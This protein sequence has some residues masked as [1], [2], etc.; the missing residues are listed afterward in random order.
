MTITALV[1]IGLLALW[2]L[3]LAARLHFGGMLETW[4][5]AELRGARL[6]MVE[7]DLFAGCGELALA[8]RPDRVY[9]T[10]TNLHVPVEYKTRN[11]FRLYESDRAQLSLQ[12]WQLR[13]TGRTTG[14]TGYVVVSELGSRKRRALAVQLGN[15][16]Y[17]EALMR[18]YHALRRNGDDAHRD[19]G[20]KC[21][22][23]G[24]RSSC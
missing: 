1:L 18:R 24:H 3:W 2:V 4:R 6:V 14:P 8:G 15:D 10:R 12:A 16:A 20:P 11:G 5:P 21:K 23:C 9:R 7:R 13:R 19:T 17:C 22:T